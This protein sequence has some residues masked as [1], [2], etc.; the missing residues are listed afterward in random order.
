MSV[1]NRPGMP[2][3]A[4]RQARR[5]ASC[6]QH[7]RAS[8]AASARGSLATPPCRAA[9]RPREHVSHVGQRTAPRTGAH[10]PAGSS[11]SRTS[12]ATDGAA[13]AQPAGQRTSHSHSH[14]AGGRP[15]RP[16]RRA[17]LREVRVWSAQAFGHARRRRAVH[18]YAL[19]PIQ[20]AE[21][22]SGTPA[23][24]PERLPPATAGSPSSAPTHARRL[25]PTHRRRW[26]SCHLSVGVAEENTLAGAVAAGHAVATRRRAR[27]GE[28]PWAGADPRANAGS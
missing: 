7:E 19:P 20:R 4:L 9:R 6:V 2:E 26:Q 16:T 3:V 12:R 15:N 24:G 11:G 5:M 22:L 17:L 18:G 13:S 27:G 1:E 23:N 8:P 28:Q 10:A 21:N 14:V 25:G